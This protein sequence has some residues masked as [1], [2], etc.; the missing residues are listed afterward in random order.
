M[1][2]IVAIYANDVFNNIDNMMSEITD[3]LEPEDF[4][5]NIKD[6]RR[7]HIQQIFRA[8]QKRYKGIAVFALADAEGNMFVDTVREHVD[9]KAINVSDRQ[10]F[11][12][13]SWTKTP[14][15]YISGASISKTTGKWVIHVV[16][17]LNFVDK[18]MTG[19]YVGS[20]AG[21]F[22][23]SVDI[24]EV[25]T[26]MLEQFNVGRPTLVTI[27]DKEGYHLVRVPF[28]PHGFDKPGMKN[29]ITVLFQEQNKEQGS[30]KFVSNLDNKRRFGHFLKLKDY[31]IYVIV[32]YEI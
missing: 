19:N 26:N 15:P 1:T 14:K 12:Y 27:R 20:F 22:I 32:A 28:N 4:L 13:L 6:E 8:Y 7:S 29:E 9:R 30:A 2:K 23:T 16:R 5:H 17:R 24:N 3:K 10:Y 21:V 31:D 18:D 25:F 11:K